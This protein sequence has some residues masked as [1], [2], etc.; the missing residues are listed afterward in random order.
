MDKKELVEMLTLV[1]CIV[2]GLVFMTSIA[3][4]L[5]RVLAWLLVAVQ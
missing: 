3:R 2:L 1:V 5:A 4:A